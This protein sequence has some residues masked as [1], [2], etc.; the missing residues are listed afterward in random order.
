MEYVFAIALAALCIFVGML[1][2]FDATPKSVMFGIA[3]RLWGGRISHRSIVHDAPYRRVRPISNVLHRPVLLNLETYEGSG[4]ACHPD[5]VYIAGGFGSK[6]W[7]YWMVCTPYPYLESRF[8]NPE[9][10]ASYDG[11]TWS[12]PDGVQNPLVP[13]P[14]KPGDHNSDPDIL[15]HKGELW[16]FFRET[17]QHKNPNENSIYLMK[18][19]DGARWSAPVKILSEQ[20]GAYLMSPSVIHDGSRFVMWTIEL[21]GGEPKLM[22]RSSADGLTWS[23][24]MPCETV[25]LDNSRLPW[26][27]DVIQEKER[28]SAVLVSCEK[29]GGTGSRTHYAYSEDYGRSWITGGFLFD[30]IYEFEAN[31]QYRG[32]L[33]RIDN[34]FQI[35]ELWYSAASRS[36]VFSIAHVK[37]VRTEDNR[38][39]PFELQ[40]HQTEMLTAPK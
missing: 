26:H 8:E 36:N 39:V 22:L 16:I 20:S 13:A 10:Y 31:V 35:Y 14:A 37:L 33:R 17:L 7:P 25:G 2:Y 21:Q 32:S 38:L 11:L 1:F 4:Q 27:I 18:S 5:V 29:F 3:R 6:K 30:Q 40:P 24:A 34:D 15:F 9:L 23:A 12:I 19:A 28:L